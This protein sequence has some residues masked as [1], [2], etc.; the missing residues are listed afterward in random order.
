MPL[1][2]VAYTFLLVERQRRPGRGL[3]LPRVRAILQEV[4]TPHLF[5]TRPPYLQRMLKLRQV[6][7][8]LTKS[9]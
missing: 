2:A 1:A 5:V 3:T 7:A 4:L 9:Y 8:D 6:A